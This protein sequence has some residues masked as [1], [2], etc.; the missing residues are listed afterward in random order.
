MRKENEHIY[1]FTDTIETLASKQGSVRET[2]TVKKKDY[3]SGFSLLKV[4]CVSIFF[5]A[6]FLTEGISMGTFK[7]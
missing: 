7:I 3:L 6:F 2:P 1:F 4:C 5:I